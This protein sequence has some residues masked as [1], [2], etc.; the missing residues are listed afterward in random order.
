MRSRL[1][2]ALI[3]LAVAIGAACTS[4]ESVEEP[5]AGDGGVDSAN[6]VGSVDGSVLDATVD[7]DG[8]SKRFCETVAPDGGQ[9][10][11]CRDFDD[12]I[13]A[14][15]G[16]NGLT[17][18]A[19][20]GSVALDSVEF[21]SA[22]NSVRARVEPNVPG[23]GYAQV[24][25]ELGPLPSRT[26]VSFDV[27]IGGAGTM[28]NDGASFFTIGT[29]GCIVILSSSQNKGTAHVQ[30][31]ANQQD[32]YF[33]MVASYARADVWAHVEASIDRTAKQ[34]EVYVDGTPSFDT[35]AI[36]LIPECIDA[37]SK[38]VVWPGLHCE[39]EST[40][41]REIRLDNILITS[42]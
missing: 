3:P 31:G 34:L 6:D 16:W 29:G 17:F 10:V 42:F 7:A 35:V 20:Q 28:A 9:I 8:G 39:A 18:D 4:F 13:G 12:G 11:Y 24:R 15:Q 25:R 33:E 2:I 36:D 19:G 5:T 26:R 23:C 1:L 30:L 38:L 40:N 27:R 41:P 22:P 14:D 37:T 32:E 21:K